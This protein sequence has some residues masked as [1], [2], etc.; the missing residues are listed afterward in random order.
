MSKSKDKKEKMSAEEI[1]INIVLFMIGVA[2]VLL[3]LGIIPHTFTS[4]L[5]II[6]L[7]W[8]L[9]GIFILTHFKGFLKVF[10]LGEEDDTN[11]EK[12]K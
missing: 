2:I 8:A 6:G 3:L 11:E 10:V 7:V 4:A 5:L 12:N 9:I 1:I